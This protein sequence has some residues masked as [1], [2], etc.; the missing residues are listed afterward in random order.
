MSDKR[1]EFGGDGDPRR[2]EDDYAKERRRM[3]VDPDEGVE[4]PL[5][6]KEND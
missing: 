2:Y 1:S 6:K 4:V 3:F 5:P